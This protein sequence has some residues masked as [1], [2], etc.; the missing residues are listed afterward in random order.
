MLKNAQKYY[1]DR[2]N[3]VRYS[4]NGKKVNKS[5]EEFGRDH[6]QDDAEGEVAVNSQAKG[7]DSDDT[8]ERA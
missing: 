1:L 6:R 2:M 8:L 7:P 4:I 5:S 3:F